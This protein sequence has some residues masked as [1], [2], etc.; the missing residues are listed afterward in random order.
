MTSGTTRFSRSAP[1]ARLVAGSAALVVALLAG[2]TNQQPVKLT[3]NFAS[4]AEWRYTTSVRIHGTI[5]IGDSVRTHAAAL[6]GVLVASPIDGM[7]S[8][9]RFRMRDASVTTDF[10]DIAQ[11]ES[12]RRQIE[13]AEAD[14]TLDEGELLVADSMEIPFLQ[15]AEWNVLRNLSRVV[16]VLPASPV[17]R[18]TTWEREKTIPLQTRHGAA[19]GHVFQ[20]FR[21]DSVFTTSGQKT[22]AALSWTY[23]YKV[24]LVNPD[25]GSL[26]TRLPGSGTG[27][28]HA[29]IN[30]TDK[31]LVSARA[32]FEVPTVTVNGI[33]IG[34]KETAEMMLQ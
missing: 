4:R 9:A 24:E 5:G 17:Y 26:L 2:C 21:L 16:P 29:E 22:V 13:A 32:G 11:T 12:A 28:G 31:C 20:L 7:P 15:A 8:R 10:M 1:P 25:S 27:T 30:V 14:L 18:G 23:T 3:V 33:T 6:A 19:I 34:W